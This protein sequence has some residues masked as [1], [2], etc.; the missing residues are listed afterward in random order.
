MEPSLKAFIKALEQMSFVLMSTVIYPYA[1]HLPSC[2]NYYH[3]IDCLASRNNNSHCLHFHLRLMTF[4][5]LSMTCIPR[6]KGI[7][8]ATPY[9]VVLLHITIIFIVFVFQKPHVSSLRVRTP[10]HV[11]DKRGK[12]HGRKKICLV[13]HT[14]TV[15]GIPLGVTCACV[16]V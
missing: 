5:S 8:V 11:C 3:T 1:P 14:Q 15:V 4:Y 9:P 13:V 10:N 16:R 6:H 7:F 12:R 2:N